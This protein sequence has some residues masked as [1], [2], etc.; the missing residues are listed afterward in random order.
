MDYKELELNLKYGRACLRD[1]LLRGEAP[2]ASHLIYT[3]EGVLDDKDRAER[4]LGIE[5][6]LA[7][8]SKAEITAVYVD[9]IDDWRFF[10]GIVKGI[11]SA[12]KASR[13]VEFRNLP[14]NV[15]L[16]IHLPA[17]ERRRNLNELLNELEE[18]ISK[19]NPL[20]I[21]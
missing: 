1:C 12:R 11:Q 7:W 4:E 3:Q 9:L 6:G 5:A 14:D 10:S 13:P 19:N 2:F 21:S 17:L 16:R 15:L 8:G 20:Q 18:F